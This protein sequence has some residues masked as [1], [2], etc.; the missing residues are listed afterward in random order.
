MPALLVAANMTVVVVEKAALDM[1]TNL[2]PKLG[3]RQLGNA[4]VS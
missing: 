1:R 3:P 4:S 2:K